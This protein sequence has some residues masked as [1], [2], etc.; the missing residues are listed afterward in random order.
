MYS[1][2][3]FNSIVLLLLFYGLAGGIKRVSALEPGSVNG[4]CKSLVEPHDFACEEHLVITTDGFILSMQRIPSGRTNSANGPPVLLQHGLLMDAATWL[5]LPPESSL[6]FV[7]ADKGFDVWLA[8]TRGTKFSQGHSSLGPDDPGFWDWSWDELVA[9][10][11]PATLQYVHD[12]TGQK[13]HY[14]G[15]SLG[16]LI[17][18]AAFSKHQLLDMLRSAAL[19][20][21]IAHLGKVTS[22]IA[23]NAA[24]NFLGEV[25]FWL[26]VKEFD[27]RGKA[28]VQLLV[29]VCAKPG[30]DCVNLLTSF[31]GQNCCLNPSVSQIF[32]THE[33]Q[34]TATKNM[35]HLSQMIR[36]GT[37]SMYDYVDVIQN[38]KHYG[39]PTPPEYNMASIPTD[40]PLF[41]TYGGADA[42]SDV[43][44]VQLL[45]DNLKDHDGDKLVVQFREDYAHADFVMGK[46]AKQAVYDPLIAFFNLQ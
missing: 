16:T 33:P 21:P 45:L 29:D 43:N 26:G 11:L 3:T 40:F 19:I 41:L 12:H 22:P 30:V 1:P 18:L 34:P 5:M 14:V 24:D 13:M 44:D 42:L 39:Q 7:L 23:R 6:A 46:N 37:I 20:S 35:I 25:L 27:P 15:H 2:N 32:L 31:T 28:G 38:I 10:D 8:N 36:S 9:F 17:A 4:I